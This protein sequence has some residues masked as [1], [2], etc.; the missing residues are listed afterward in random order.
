M[1]IK[2]SIFELISIKSEN[3]YDSVNIQPNELI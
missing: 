2:Q 1:E 3:G